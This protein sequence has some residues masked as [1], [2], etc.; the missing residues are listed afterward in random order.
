MEEYTLRSTYTQLPDLYL[1]PEPDGPDVMT[2]LDI[3]LLLHFGFEEE[4][5]G[6]WWKRL[7]SGVSYCCH[8]GGSGPATWYRTSPTGPENW[9]TGPMESLGY[10]TRTQFY[11]TFRGEK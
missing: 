8:L 5:F 3:P 11:E 9:Q 1:V 7:G 2:E 10:M 6:S 4:V